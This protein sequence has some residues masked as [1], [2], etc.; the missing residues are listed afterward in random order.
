MLRLSD[1]V[2]TSF[3]L[4]VTAVAILA[5]TALASIMVVSFNLLVLLMRQGI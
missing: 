1:D 5:L 3:G 4:V 2:S